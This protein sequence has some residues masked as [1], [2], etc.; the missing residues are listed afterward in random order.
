MKQL[1][2]SLVL[3]A[4]LAGCAEEEDTKTAPADIGAGKAV[5]Q[6]QCAGCHGLDG[7]GAAP[8]IPDMAAQ[9]EE[10]LIESL[11]AYNEGKRTHAALRDM[12]TELSAADIRNVA[13]FY[14]SL[15]PLEDT[16]AP[17]EKTVS[18]YEQG[19][20]SVWPASSRGISS[21]PCGL[22]WTGPGASPE[23]RCCGNSTMSISRAWRSTTHPRH[24]QSALRR[25]PEIR[26]PA[27]R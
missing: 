26:R 2:L 17:T 21:P 8:G 20:A 6:A 12:T 10:Y 15:P 1:A 5:A 23:K 4:M 19:E 27:S 7:R 24:R 22:I 14:A 11:Q 9:V 25:R 18:P 16:G 13:G 3:A